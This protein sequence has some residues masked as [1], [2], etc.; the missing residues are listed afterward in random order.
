M[1]TQ[2]MTHRIVIFITL[3]LITTVGL[4]KSYMVLGGDQSL[5]VVIAQ[6]LDAGKILYKDLFDYKQPGIFLFY[7]AAGKMIG[8]SDF[9]IHLFELGY[10]LLFTVILMY[11]LKDY[12]IF[13]ANYFHA[14]LPLFIVG[15]YY[16]NA[17]FFH[18]TQLE[19]LINFP[20]FLIIWLLDRVYKTEQHVFTTYF[21]IGLLIGIVILCKLVFAPIIFAFLVIHFIFTIK[22]KSFIHIIKKQLFP[23][24]SGFML[25]I[26]VFVGYITY[27]QIEH[28]VVDIFFK[29]PAIV[30]GLTDQIN[31]NR[32]YLSIAWFGRKMILLVLLAAI[33]VW[34]TPRKELHFFA[35]IIAWG[36][37]GLFV[38][39]MQKTSWWSYH[40]QLLYVPIGLFAAM[41]LDFVIYHTLQAINSRKSV[42]TGLIVVSFV[43]MAFN[44][45]YAALKQSMLSVNFTK[46]DS[47]DY[48]RDDAAN[49]ISMIKPEDSIFICG[50]PRMYVLTS[51]L[52]ELSTNGWILEYYLD[53]QWEDFHTEF[54]AKPPTYLFVKND[55]DRLIESKSE[56]LWQLIMTEYQEIETVENGKWYKKLSPL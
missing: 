52:P 55:Y 20:L 15:V 7:L 6:L 10:W 43:A 23:L 33:G 40:F 21:A 34:I 11:S 1:L 31:P 3:S 51:H 42:V 5:F 26:L 45:Q 47:F 46:L 50:N 19:A 4:L 38:I 14:L 24:I 25:P 9:D 8:W 2:H 29:I 35:M 18:L 16:C 41:G 27:F 56:K 36:A 53:F 48:A 28:L 49:I 39:L 17:T 22:Y 44:N 32:L 54:R 30:I 37:V 12:P 13:R